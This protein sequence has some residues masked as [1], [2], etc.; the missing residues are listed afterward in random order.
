[1]CMEEKEVLESHGDPIFQIKEFE[2]GTRIDCRVKADS[3][4]EFEVGPSV[5]LSP[6]DVE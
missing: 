2:C 6:Q 1:M 5:S 4:F 3:K